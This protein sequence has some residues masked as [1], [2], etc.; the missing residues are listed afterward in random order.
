VQYQ[1][2]NLAVESLEINDLLDIKSPSAILL[3]DCYRIPVEK[4][5]SERYGGLW[6]VKDFKGMDDYASHP[7]AVL[8][9]G[10]H[11]VFIKLSEAA[12]GL[13][14][15]EA[16][17]AGLQ[18]LSERA[19]VLIPLPIGIL[20]MENGVI[21]ALEAAEAVERTPQRWRE[22]GRTLACIHQVKGECCGLERQGYFGP[23][24]QDNRPMQ[25]WLTF[26]IERRLYPRL[27]GAIDSGNL[28]T[29]SIRKIE[30]L[31]GRLP[32]LGI[33]EVEPCLLHGDAQ[34]NNFI[35]TMRGAMVIDPAVHY[36][37]PE[38][39]L[40]YVDYFQ[41][42]PEDVFLGY[43]EILP[44]KPG[45][46]ERRD[47]WRVSAYLAAVEVEGKM[48]LEKLMNAIQPYC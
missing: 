17:L 11:A 40:A 14:Q 44:I 32:S 22:I 23:L 18:L 5:V 9:D 42:V 2:I 15:F 3:S 30:Q 25:D 13:D 28:P 36:G 1:I 19:G 10:K 39:D 37:N 38:M 41:P 35:S 24:Y 6:R 31:I 26:Y 27:M 34:Q 29:D 46:S 45:F 20:T 4:A 43:Q 12:H 47:L 48:H 7:A 16:E 8:T 33:P 21:L